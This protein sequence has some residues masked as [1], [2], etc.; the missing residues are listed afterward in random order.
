[1]LCV[2]ELVAAIKDKIPDFSIH[3]SNLKVPTAKFV[4]S[5]YVQVLKEVG[6]DINCKSHQQKTCVSWTVWRHRDVCHH[7]Q[8]YMLLSALC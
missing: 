6:V 1:M 2:E 5:Y 8:N 3:M 7:R 4:E